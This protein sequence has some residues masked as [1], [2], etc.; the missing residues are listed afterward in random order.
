MAGS[1]PTGT[2]PGLFVPTTPMFDVGQLED[3]KLLKQLVVQL[4]QSIN[5]ISL[6][7]NQKDSALYYQEE[8]VNGQTYFPNPA[9]SSTTPQT[10]SPRQVFRTVVNMGQLPNAGAIAVP[11]NIPN[12]DSNFSFTRIYATASNPVGLV[13]IPIPSTNIAGS[14]TAIAVDAVNVNIG[15]NWNATAFTICYAVLEY[16]KN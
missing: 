13:Y 12:I 1:Y 14:I 2:N 8:F 6:A 10:P 9:L 3:P 7:L 5:N 16:I 4:I 15:T 11:H